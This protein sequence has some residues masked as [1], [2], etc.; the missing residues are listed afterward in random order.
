MDAVRSSEVPAVTARPIRCT[1]VYGMVLTMQMMRSDLT[2][3]DAILDPRAAD[4]AHMAAIR[5]M[6]DECEIP[7]A[8]GMT[9]IYARTFEVAGRRWVAAEY[10]DIAALNGRHITLSDGSEIRQGDILA[11]LVP[12]RE[13]I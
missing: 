13:E 2:D 12:S 3:N 9:V 7:L 10:E 1:T 4:A 8:P 6:S 5:G 11:V